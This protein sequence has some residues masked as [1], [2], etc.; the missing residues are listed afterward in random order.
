M[1][2]ENVEREKLQGIVSKKSLQ[3]A[4]KKFQ[5]LDFP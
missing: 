4:Q 2:Y 5:Y 1:S 3:E